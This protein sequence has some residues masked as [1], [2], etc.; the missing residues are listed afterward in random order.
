VVFRKLHTHTKQEALPQLP[1]L[2]FKT[3]ALRNLTLIVPHFSNQE[4]SIAVVE[5][6]I[7]CRPLPHPETHTGPHELLPFVLGG[8]R[9][10]RNPR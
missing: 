6:L 4:Q 9:P 2:L 10:E 8:S 5:R 1:M 7:L 3:P